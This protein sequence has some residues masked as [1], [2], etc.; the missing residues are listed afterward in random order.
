[1]EIRDDL[2]CLFSSEI[3]REGSDV[4]IT[5]PSD[6]VELGDLEPGR[7]YRIAILE[8]RNGEGPATARSSTGAPTPPVEEGEHVDLE[9]ESIGDQGDG[10]ARVDRGYVVIVPDTNVG[11]R[12]TAEITTVKENMAFAEVVEHHRVA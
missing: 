7:T 5:V 6:E 1:M 4:V 2:L 9:V 10:I 8:Q 3:D 12:V 11:D